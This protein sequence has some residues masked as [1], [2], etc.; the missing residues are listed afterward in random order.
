MP[1]FDGARIN[2]ATYRYYTVS[3]GTPPVVSHKV[4]IV[5][6]YE[7]GNISP[8]SGWSFNMTSDINN[9]SYGTLAWAESIGPPGTIATVTKTISLPLNIGLTPVT[10]VSVSMETYYNL[11]DGAYYSTKAATNVSGGGGTGTGTSSWMLW[12]GIAAAA[13]L[14]IAFIRRKK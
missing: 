6:V 4:D 9:Q 1:T 13:L 14:V 3:T 12:G 7:V 8:V 11:V 2:S 5:V 10:K